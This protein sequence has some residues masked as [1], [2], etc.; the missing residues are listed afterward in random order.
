MGVMPAFSERL[1]P[2]TIKM[3]TAYVHTRGGGEDEVIAAD[4][5]A[6]LAV[7]EEAVDGADEQP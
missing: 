7:A 3:L 5:D 1:D 6:E 4:P 2:V